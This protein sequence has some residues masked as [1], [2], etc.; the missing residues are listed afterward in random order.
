MHTEIPVMFSGLAF[1]IW[2]S[3]NR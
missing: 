2:K 1:Q 3:R